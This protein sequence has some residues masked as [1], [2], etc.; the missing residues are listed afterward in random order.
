MPG[1]RNPKMSATGDVSDL[2]AT[3]NGV[4][5]TTMVA[6]WRNIIMQDISLIQSDRE[7]NGLATYLTGNTACSLG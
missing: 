1:R 6:I 5:T 4:L 2:K 7:G 3:S